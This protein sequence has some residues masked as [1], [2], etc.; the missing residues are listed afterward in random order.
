MKNLPKYLPRAFYELLL[1][2]GAR[3]RLPFTGYLALHFAILLLFSAYAQENSLSDGWASLVLFGLFYSHWVNCCKRLLSA[4]KSR[5]WALFC[6]VPLAVIIW[7]FLPVEEDSIKEMDFSRPAAS[8]LCPRLLEKLSPLV[9][10]GAQIFLVLGIEASMTAE[11]EAATTRLL[12]SITLFFGWLAFNY[13]V[14]EIDYEDSIG[15]E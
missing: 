2:V 1:P 7:M 15:I 4:G 3:G 14:D 13:I 9:K 6:P 12:T 10:F 5:I 11:Y 8:I